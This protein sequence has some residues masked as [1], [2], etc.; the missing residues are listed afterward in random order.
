M[1]TTKI[2]YLDFYMKTLSKLVTFVILS[3]A[4]LPFAPV[5][6]AEN[7]LN[8]KIPHL[9]SGE[10]KKTVKQN[11]STDFEMLDQVATNDDEIR[12]S[13]ANFTLDLSCKTKPA[14]KCG[15]LGIYKEEVKPENLITEH[16]S[17]PLPIS[18]IASKLSAGKNKIVIAFFDGSKTNQATDTKISF[19]FNYLN[20]V[21]DPKIAVTKPSNGAVLLKSKNQ[22]FVVE[23]EKFKL[24][25]G[26]A[27]M[28][29][30]NMYYNEVKPE[31]L[32]AENLVTGATVGDKWL[33]NINSEDY[34]NFT[35]IP[36]GLD[37]KIIFV[38]V[39]KVGKVTNFQA[40]VSVK[41]NYQ[42]TLDINLP[43]IKIIEPVQ[44]SSNL[45]IDGDKKFILKVD[46]F[47]LLSTRPQL[48]N[49]KSESNKG[50][51]QITIDNETV[52]PYYSR[53]DFTLNDLKYT[54]AE[55]KKSLKVKLVDV[56]FVAIQ[57]LAEDTIEF[58]YKKPLKPETTT[59]LGY[60][61]NWKIYT[62]VASIIFV[63]AGI[64]ILLI[65]A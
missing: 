25:N 31:N 43:K 28:G 24:G 6:F 48:D 65:K 9:R 30:L 14:I 53:T 13:W 20:Q 59:S 47:E 52:S 55:G 58:I 12:Y 7:V 15:Y 40:F 42:N 38:L 2:N 37:T 3:T 4:L 36:D 11:S 26:E 35:K 62:I 22:E 57:P 63:I 39:D 19:T 32:I 41:A 29:R 49:L 50:F 23:I 64:S 54:K 1:M 34:P 16:A 27:S 46:N 33:V 8:L 17:S 60:E 10:T 51:L 45:D 44:N 5:V 56:N 18:K 61:D 21:S